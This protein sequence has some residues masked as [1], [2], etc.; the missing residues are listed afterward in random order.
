[1]IYLLDTNVVSELIRPNASPNVSQFVDAFEDRLHVS[2]ITLAEIRF[3]IA[4]MEHG[5]RR[6]AFENW[7]DQ[8]V[9]AR[10]GSRIL[11]IDVDIAAAWGELMAL[12]ERRGTN[13]KAMDGL[14]A[15]TAVARDLT[16]VTRNIRDF[17]RL[18]LRLLDPWIE[19]P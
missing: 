3:G 7:L 9:S 12:S 1:M 19:Q 8:D 11:N 15:A 10:F 2:V 14:L 5:R 4:R 13:L 6:L 16:L 17:D 18:G